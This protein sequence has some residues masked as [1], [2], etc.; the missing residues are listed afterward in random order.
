MGRALRTGN[1]FLRF[2]ERKLHRSAAL[3]KSESD[4][5]QR[6]GEEKVTEQQSETK[7]IGE[8]RF[9]NSTG[10][11]PETFRQTGTPDRW[12]QYWQKKSRPEGRHDENTL[13][14]IYGD[15]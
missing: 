15:G 14:I 5:Q 6:E 2:D 13:S 8:G 7:V 9:A 1:H 3:P 10:K 4:T 11:A 12:K